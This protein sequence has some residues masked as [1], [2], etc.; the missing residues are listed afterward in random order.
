[1]FDIFKTAMKREKKASEV[2]VWPPQSEENVKAVNKL[3]GKK[4]LV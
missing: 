4:V 3:R 2:E 1:M